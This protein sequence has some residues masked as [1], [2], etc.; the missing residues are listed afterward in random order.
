MTKP[1]AS[2]RLLEFLGRLKAP[3]RLR[4]PFVGDL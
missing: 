1:G 2:I 3:A 4:E